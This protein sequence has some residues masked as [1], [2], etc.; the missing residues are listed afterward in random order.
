MIVSTADS[1]LQI[2]PGEGVLMGLSESP[3]L[4]L[5]AF[6][7]RVVEWNIAMR[8]PTRGMVLR[9]AMTGNVV[10]GSLTAFADDLARVLEVQPA[11]ASRAR[12]LLELND[13]ELDLA[14]GTQ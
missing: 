1:A 5:S 11:S 4:F 3:M 7:E 6:R 2:V 8:P 12:Q 14:L 10:D 13:S 9:C